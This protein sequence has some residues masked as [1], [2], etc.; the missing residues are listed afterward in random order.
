MKILILPIFILLVLVQW[1]VPGKMIWNKE[2]VHLSGKEFK[3]ETEPVDPIHPFKGR[4]V[5]LN[6]VSDTFSFDSSLQIEYGKDIYVELVE[7]RNGFA[8]VRNISNTIP[9]NNDY[10]ITAS[11]SSISSTTQ[12]GI[13]RSLVFIEYPFE[14]YYLEEYKAPK[15]EEIFRSIGRDTLHTT[16]AI[17]K[18]LNGDAVIKDI[19]LNNRSINEHFR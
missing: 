4:Y 10:Y 2:K 14:E 5:T 19:I 11:I 13:N 15:V 3:F 6:F 9:T 18:V 1:Y 8:E 17:V 7:N 16:Y 12:N